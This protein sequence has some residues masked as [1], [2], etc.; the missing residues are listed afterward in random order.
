M[1]PLKIFGLHLNSNHIGAYTETFVSFD[2]S[3]QCYY[4]ILH[5]L[6]NILVRLIKIQIQS[7]RETAGERE[8]I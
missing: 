5:N 2:V 1:W 7:E 4:A 6:H 3:S 8:K